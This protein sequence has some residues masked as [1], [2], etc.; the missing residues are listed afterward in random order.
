MKQPPYL[1]RGDQVKIISTAR[2]ISRSE[3]EPAI[4]TFTDWGLKV[5]LGDHL[6]EESDQFAGTETQ[7][8]SDLQAAIEDPEIKA[9]FFARGGYGSVQLVDQ[10]NWDALLRQPKWLVGYSDITVFHSHINVHYDIESLHAAMPVNIKADGSALSKPA[11]AS[12]HK[13]LF[14]DELIYQFDEHPLNQNFKQTIEGT[15]VGGNLSILYSLSG[16]P[17]QLSG[18]GKII[19]IED[20]DEYLY[21]ID[22]MMMNLIRSGILDGCQGVLIGGMSDMN[23]NQVPYGKTAEEIIVHRLKTLG[24]PL[25]FGFPAGH[26]HDNRS[27][28]MGREVSI[29]NLSGKVKLEFHGRAQ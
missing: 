7:R 16:S 9:I 14:G 26:V 12:I 5:S 15:L 6:F 24:V 28:I 10:I 29:E 1:K 13:A 8:T 17:S 23:D 25:I 22:R 3:V 21:H 2:K 4:Q 20:L 18:E 19:F 27:L 11:L